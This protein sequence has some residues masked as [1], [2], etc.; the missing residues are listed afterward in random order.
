MLS[1]AIK[2]K[3]DYYS[4]KAQI[5]LGYKKY[6]DFHHSTFPTCLFDE[7]THKVHLQCLTCQVKCI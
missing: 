6:F 5:K 3:I 1:R 4:V 7:K 2:I